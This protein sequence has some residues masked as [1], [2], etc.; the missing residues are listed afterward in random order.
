MQIQ[1]GEILRWAPSH[2]AYLSSNLLPIRSIAPPLSTAKC[3]ASHQTPHL[4][5]PPIRP[6]IPTT[7]SEKSSRGPSTCPQTIP[8]CQRCWISLTPS[9]KFWSIFISR[10]PPPL[11]AS[12]Q[13]QRAISCPVLLPWRVNRA[14]VKTHWHQVSCVRLFARLPPWAGMLASSLFNE[15]SNTII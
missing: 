5:G 4:L 14:E 12:P 10:V 11:P 6:P 13:P 9:Y 8:T 1:R 2:S 7:K 15:L 3:H